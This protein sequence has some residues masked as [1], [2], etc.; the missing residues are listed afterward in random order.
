MSTTET[1]LEI[2]A[3][4]D[5]LSGNHEKLWTSRAPRPLAKR[6]VQI[7]D[8]AGWQAWRKHLRRRGKPAAIRSL[9]PGR[10]S[11][12]VWAMPAEPAGPATAE[13]VERLG[14]LG[15]RPLEAQA[16]ASLATEVENWIWS[17]DAAERSIPWALETVAWAQ[18]LPRLSAQLPASAWWRLL[19]RLLA[20]VKEGDRTDVASEPVVNQ[21]LAGELPL[22]LMHQ[23]P[24]LTACRQLRESA[25]AALSR[26][27]AE[28]LDG[29]GLL[30]SAHLPI[31]RT[32]CAC[33]TR[34]RAIGGKAAW[35]RESE[36]QFR[37][38]VLEIVRL[39]RAGGAQV[40][41]D[42]ETGR[43]TPRMFELALRLVGRQPV[44][45]IAAKMLPSRRRGATSRGAGKIASAVNSEWAEIAVLQPSW[46]RRGPKVTLAYAEQQVQI[47]LEDAGELIWSGP[48]GL[49]LRID[50]ARAEQASNWEEVCWFSDADAD[51]VEIEAKL[52][53]GVTVQR[54]V[55]LT[56][57]DRCLLLADAVVGPRPG[58]I[59]YES[60]LPI[61]ATVEAK[62]AAETR[63]VS[64]AGRRAR[65][66]V[67]P[68]ALPEWRIDPRRGELIAHEGNL[69]LQQTVDAQRLYAPLLIDLDPERAG[70]G[71]TW[72]QL[73]IAETRQIQPAE[74]AVGYRAQSGKSQWVVYR[75]LAKPGIRTVLGQNL[76]S[77]FRRRR[78]VGRN[79]VN[80][81]DARQPPERESGPSTRTD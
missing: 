26:G 80:F 51:Y 19:Q 55:L 16:Q 37:L 53:G 36:K 73:T 28:L 59:H 57:R 15:W 44:A 63:E 71:L 34:C 1:N 41:S 56:R 12:L 43:W 13:L 24:E 46:Q 74:V 4:G 49:D 8:P 72:R 21:V 11:P 17:C 40:L 62:P 31:L 79:R 54:Q 70:K 65:V 66:A 67:L 60:K 64:L 14:D 7:D 9:F 48:W 69:C 68:L 33:W 39:S 27:I 52:A 45:R 78:P 6:Y 76:S 2:G 32:L 23:F 47:E 3:D 29:E 35:D 10:R 25:S 30:Q 58:R 18:A 61:A 81:R 77:E 75:S 50:G 22:T 38:F 5:L 42:G 20:L